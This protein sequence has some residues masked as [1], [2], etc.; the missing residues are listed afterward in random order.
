MYTGLGSNSTK[1]GKDA[2][3]DELRVSAATTNLKNEKDFIVTYVPGAER[4]FN[5]PNSKL[6]EL[7]FGSRQTSEYA[8]KVNAD[9]TDETGTE[10]NR[11]KGLLDDTRTAKNVHLLTDIPANA[12]KYKEHQ[13]R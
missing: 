4:P 3:V 8:V 7:D 5:S 6:G 1:I 2:N 9:M 13:N 12:A 10:Q 11:I